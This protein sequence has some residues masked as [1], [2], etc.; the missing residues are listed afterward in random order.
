MKN[1]S[2]QHNCK[3]RNKSLPLNQDSVKVPIEKYLQTP[4]LC[5]NHQAIEVDAENVPDSFDSVSRKYKLDAR[6]QMSLSLFG[7]AELQKKMKNLCRMQHVTSCL[8]QSS[9]FSRIIYHFFNCLKSTSTAIAKVAKNVIEM[10][11]LQYR[12]WR[13]GFLLQTY[14]TSSMQNAKGWN[15]NLKDVLWPKRL[16][17]FSWTE[18]AC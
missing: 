17:V 10:L 9:L 8:L 6:Q 15:S 4:W 2:Q 7:P 11:M 12:W 16:F 13:V 14:Q 5:L 3:L 18:E 1:E